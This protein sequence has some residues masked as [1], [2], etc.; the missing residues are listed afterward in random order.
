MNVRRFRPIK[1]QPISPRS[2]Q[3]SLAVA[4]RDRPGAL[5]DR[6]GRLCAACAIDLLSPV[7]LLPSVRR[8]A[9]RFWVSAVLVLGLIPGSFGK[10]LGLT[11]NSRGDLIRQGQP[12]RGIGVNY[13]DAFI[14]TLRNPGYRS[15]RQG[16]SQLGANGI[17]FARLAAGGYTSQDWQLYLGDK[18][19]YFHRLDDVVASAEK[20]HVGLIASLFWSIGSVSEAVH[21]SPVHWA[22]SESATR[23]F[24]R[25]YTQEVVSRYADSPAIWG[26]EFSCELSLPL[27]KRPGQGNPARTLTLATFRSAALDFA[28]VVREL[29][30]DRI[31]LTGN[32]LPR[33]AAYHN[34]HAG[35]VSVDTEEQFGQILLRDNP[36]PFNPICIHVSPAAIAGYFADRKVS[37][38][39]LIEASM[40]IAHSAGKA[41]Y[42]EE[43]VPVPQRPKG[44]A[45]MTEREYFTSELKAIEASGVPIASVWVYDRKLVPDR[46]N[47]TFSN[48]YSYM[49]R[50]IAAFDRSM[51]LARRGDE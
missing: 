7:I 4:Q 26:W 22:D 12:Y 42:V 14:R 13:F 49:L 17:P 50:M 34:S 23:Q 18:E 9:T 27:D 46:S 21:E 32:S 28:Q 33:A 24:M 2:Q 1:F 29:D 43:F 25:R 36:G 30:P 19:S 44:L 15:Y 38:Q 40:Q 10:D 41:L 16:L 37:Y 6:A 47:V 45:G 39:E 48:E 3:S 51:H 8:N 20:A 31:I 11:V 35:R 5:P